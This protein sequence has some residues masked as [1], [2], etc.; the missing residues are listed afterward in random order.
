MR[1]HSLR[2]AVLLVLVSLPALP[3][4]AL[5]AR[6]ILDRAKAL[7]DGERKW[8]NRI[9]RMTLQAFDAGGDQRQRQI[10]VF[11]KRATVDEEKTLS[12]ILAPAEVRGTGFLQWSHRGRDDDQWLYLPEFRRTRQ[13]AAR[14][15]DESFVGTDFSYRDLE[16]VAKI[17]R[18]TEAEGPSVRGNDE[19]IAGRPCYG[20]EL[21]P[22][23]D[24][25]PYKKIVLNLDRDRLVARKLAFFDGSGSNVKVLTTDDLRDVGAIPTPYRIEMRNLKKGSHTVVTLDEV[26]FNT[27][28]A[29]DLFTQRY[30]ER[31]AP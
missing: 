18:W 19:T 6:E 26:Q 20:I 28:L 9:E 24:D 29:D 10:Q 22:K 4:A 11:T 15:K 1:K 25:T 12:F 13:I 27:K 23:Q 21:Q 30:L 17:L 14:V 31:G 7:E 2:V 16:I 3:A 8:D 5:T